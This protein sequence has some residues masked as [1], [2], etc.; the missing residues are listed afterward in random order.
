MVTD[1]RRVG[2]ARTLAK[3]IQRGDSFTRPKSMYIITVPTS[4]YTRPLQWISKI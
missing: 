4:C 2:C 1:P 3:S